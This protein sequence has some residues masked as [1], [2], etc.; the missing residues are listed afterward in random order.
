VV[1]CLI[2]LFGELAGVPMYFAFCADYLH[3]ALGVPAQPDYNAA[4]FELAFYRVVFPLLVQ[5]GLVALPALSGL[6]QGSEASESRLPWRIA[7]GIAAAVTVAAMVIQ[8]QAF[9]L[10]LNPQVVHAYLQPGPWLGRGIRLLQYVVYWPLAYLLVREIS[11][12]RDRT[13][14]G[15]TAATRR[16][17]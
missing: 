1:L 12:R 17:L 3:R 2:L 5:V 9:W 6:R 11:R 8:N 14:P 15:L 4:V 10:F 7:P 13:V 16:T